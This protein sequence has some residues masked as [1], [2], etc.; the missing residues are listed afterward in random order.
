MFPNITDP[1]IIDKLTYR[2]E[3]II[4]RFSEKISN[5]FELSHFQKMIKNFI[6]PY[7]PYKSLLLYWATGTGKTVAAL[8]ITESYQPLIRDLNN[9]GHF[10]KIYIIIKNNILKDQFSNTLIEDYISREKYVSREERIRYKKKYENYIL[11]PTVENKKSYDNIKN[12][13]KN[14]IEKIGHYEFISYGK[15]RNMLEGTGAT[16]Q[17]LSANNSI[18]V[19][20][21]AHD[22]ENNRADDLIMKLK[23]TSTNLK[24]LLMTAT[25][26]STYPYEIIN[27]L[28]F[29]RPLDKQLVQTDYFSVNDNENILLPHAA[30][31]IGLLSRGYVSYYRIS[32]RT[33]DF[34]KQI[35]MG[36]ILPGFKYLKIIKCEMSKFHTDTYNNVMEEYA[37]IDELNDTLTIRK[38]NASAITSDIVLPWTK[39]IGISYQSY[40][41]LRNKSEE[42]LNNNKITMLDDGVTGDI[43]HISVI[44]KYSTKYFNMIKNIIDA[45]K[46][47]N[48]NIL[49]FHS[50]IANGINIISNVLTENGIIH[51]NNKK[52]V[53]PNTRCYR[54]GIEKSKHTTTDHTFYPACYVTLYGEVK[55]EQRNKYLKEYNSVEN[56]YGKLIKIFV[57]TTVLREGWDFKRIR[58]VHLMQYQNSINMEKQVIGR[59]I[60]KNSHVDMKKK[61]RNVE[62]FR[63]ISVLNG[64]E[65]NSPEYI[66]YLHQEK[67][68]TG[69]SKI[70]KSLMK[71]SINSEL[72]IDD[73]S[74][75]IIDDS[76]KIDEM[77]FDAY[78]YRDEMYVYRI[79]IEKL[80]EANIVWTAK[81]LFNKI[82][83]KI[84]NLVLYKY[85]ND[86]YLALTLFEM[87][88][89]KHEFTVNNI[90]GYII[91]RG[92]HY[93][94]NPT[95]MNEVS[96]IEDRIQT[97]TTGSNMMVYSQIKSDISELLESEVKHITTTSID[98]LMINLRNTKFSKITTIITN[99]SISTKYE[100]IKY[101]IEQHN[102]IDD[103][104]YDLKIF[105]KVFNIFSSIMITPKRLTRNSYT[106]NN[107]PSNHIKY[108]GAIFGNISKCYTGEKWQSCS[109]TY[110][111]KKI[112]SLVT[113]SI[114]G[115]VEV[116]TNNTSPKFKII[117][118]KRD[119]KHPYSAGNIDGRSRSR[120]RECS[121][122][123][124]KNIKKIMIKLGLEFNES[125]RGH[126]WCTLIKEKLISLND[127]KVGGK[128]YFFD[129]LEMELLRDD[130]IFSF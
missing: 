21:E 12:K 38:K 124:R 118:N 112:T 86:D 56:K 69:I 100:L 123:K 18:F 101:A 25:P 102:L 120:G 53:H 96:R 19:F 28:N 130:G 99:L 61:N 105:K 65:E 42:W 14:V 110:T 87:V 115:F 27:I 49:I 109:K 41:K 40:N 111:T 127:K 74:S 83:A 67:R 13:I 5:K 52:I 129:Y 117:I 15:F 26:M 85:K 92:I 59:A 55:Q 2:K 107:N 104:D 82:E 16:D 24:I 116:K 34:P 9:I 81:E 73:T 64:N 128:R 32:S 113:N 122:I 7:T 103:K 94:F 119:R 51:Y 36:K 70:E 89:S 29:L 39:D 75:I 114:Y 1:E 88:Q 106:Y 4:H 37:D 84:L 121:S 11:S 43:L 35:N 91:K 8:T 108:I 68:F 17:L 46:N 77:A 47:G 23:Q 6:N 66:Q 33:E 50:K 30:K 54:C 93:I 20:D 97:I 90:P 95:I 78:F 31:K 48:K 44:K 80:F 3:Q 76:K 98:E 71:N 126:E 22:I 58:Q 60:R 72:C 45:L 57:G 62:I 10:C 63:Y 79:F 125:L